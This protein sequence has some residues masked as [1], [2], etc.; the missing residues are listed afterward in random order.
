[1]MEHYQRY[2]V[3]PLRHGPVLQLDETSGVAIPAL[4]A[5]PDVLHLPKEG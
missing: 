5:E 1:M 2:H 4:P 3:V